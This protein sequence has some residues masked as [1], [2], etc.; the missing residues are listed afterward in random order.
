M[1]YTKLGCREKRKDIHVI[2]ETLSITNL[3]V[4]LA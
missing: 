2:K 1:L 4:P 3:G